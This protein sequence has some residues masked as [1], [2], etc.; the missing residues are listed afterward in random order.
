MKYLFLLLIL[1]TTIAKADEKKC[2]ELDS[3]KIKNLVFQKLYDEGVKLN[4]F[5]NTNNKSCSDGDVNSLK[6]LWSEYKEKSYMIN[7]GF[8]IESPTVF[9]DVTCRFRMK[10]GF[11]FKDN[12]NVDQKNL[13]PSTFTLALSELDGSISIDDEVWKYINSYK[14]EKNELINCSLIF[15]A[16]EY[17]RRFVLLQP[18]RFQYSKASFIEQID[19]NFNL[20]K[21]LSN[22]FQ[23]ENIKFITIDKLFS[24]DEYLVS[25]LLGNWS[26]ASSTF[27][28]LDYK[29]TFNEN[30]EYSEERSH[31]RDLNG[32]TPIYVYTD[33]KWIVLN[34]ILLKAVYKD[35][36]KNKELIAVE[37][38]KLNYVSSKKFECISKDETLTYTKEN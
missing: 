25:Y 5:C 30:K 22:K 2:F 34:G 1:L 31:T 33:G 35:E 38:C 8:W 32:T 18:K 9:W 3:L 26:Y 13:F 4:L 29:L 24:K 17:F 20:E 27:T 16:F 15:Y 23:N 28:S 14:C 19:K 36:K 37:R 10:V 21:Y 12:L 11:T 6:E 7:G